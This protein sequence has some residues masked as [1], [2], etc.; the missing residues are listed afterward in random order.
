MEP[1]HDYAHPPPEAPRQILRLPGNQEVTL[2]FAGTGSA[3]LKA[4]KD[5]L[6]QHS[7]KKMINKGFI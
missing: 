7:I 3:A 2:T 6:I 5:I 1:C 4:A